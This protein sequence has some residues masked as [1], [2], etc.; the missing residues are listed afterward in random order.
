MRCLN[1]NFSVSNS[2]R[3]NFRINDGANTFVEMNTILDP[4]NS[5][6]TN[7]N[8]ADE[9]NEVS[10]QLKD[11]KQKHDDSK[12][13]VSA[14]QAEF[15]AIKKEIASTELQEKEAEAPMVANATRL[16]QLR[17][18]I[19][20]TK[21]KIEEERMTKR[22]YSH[23]LHRMEQ[24][25]I[26]T[27]IKTNELEKSLTTKRAVIAMEEEKG[28]GSKEERLQSKGIFDGLMKNIEKEQRDR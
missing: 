1:L 3:F 10:I 16:Q 13:L 7:Q 9:I 26:A 14:K 24:D 4:A 18:A 6:A 8:T 20:D 28:R 22:T 27:K 21:G 12:K 2:K 19:Q 5:S 11:I 23:M 17:E 15:D 25:Y